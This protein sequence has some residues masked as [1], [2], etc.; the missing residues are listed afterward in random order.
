MIVGRPEAAG[1]YSYAMA[2]S[3]LSFAARRAGPIAK[4]TP[5]TAANTT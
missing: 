1:R 2:S 4:T 3:T 5:I